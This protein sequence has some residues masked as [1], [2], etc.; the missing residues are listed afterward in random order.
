[1]MKTDLETDL[2]MDLDDLKTDIDNL[3]KDTMADLDRAIDKSFRVNSTA[4][5]V[6]GTTPRRE[7]HGGGVVGSTAGG[8][9]APT[10]GAGAGK[11]S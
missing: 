5:A 6:V 10:A 1:M 11:G 9:T 7:D 8:G 4:G 3:A 2:K